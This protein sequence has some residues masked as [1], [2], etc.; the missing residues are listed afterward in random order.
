[1]SVTW[2]FSSLFKDQMVCLQSTEYFESNKFNSEINPLFYW[3]PV[4][5]NSKPISTIF[6]YQT[7]AQ[8]IDLF[9]TSKMP[10]MSSLKTA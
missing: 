2:L 6:F 7:T 3:Q 4:M 1:M 10:N 8:L 5:Y 9:L